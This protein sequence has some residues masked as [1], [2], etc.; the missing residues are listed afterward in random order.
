MEL[1]SKLLTLL[2]LY[3]FRFRSVGQLYADQGFGGQQFRIGR[4]QESIAR[5]QQ[6]IHVTFADAI[7]GGAAAPVGAERSG[8]FAVPEASHG[9]RDGGLERGDIGHGLALLK[10]GGAGVEGNCGIEFVRF[11]KKKKKTVFS[12]IRNI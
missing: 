4:D 12:L 5:Q 3:S 11:M 7:Q 2:C 8:E 10:G 1:F 6:R 9:R